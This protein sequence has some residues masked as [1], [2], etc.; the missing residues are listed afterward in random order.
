MHRTPLMRPAVGIGLLILAGAC[1]AHTGTD[2]GTHHGFSAGLLHPFA[3]LDHLVAALA[4]G[5]W[6][7]LRAPADRLRS[8][9]VPVIFALALILGTGLP[10]LGVEPPVFEPLIAASLLTVGLALAARGTPTAPLAM[11]AAVAFGLPHGAAHGAALPAAAAIAGMLLGTALL[12]VLGHW[13]GGR[14][15]AGQS[16]WPRAAGLLTAGLGLG[17]ITSLIRL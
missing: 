2:A 3:G 6:S 10:A 14:A 5:L 7:G 16:T 9:A 15:R 12:L 11:L 17:L 13:L 4:I 8:L 1:A